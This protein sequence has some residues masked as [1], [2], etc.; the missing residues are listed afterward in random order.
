M[1]LPEGRLDPVLEEAV[2]SQP[3]VAQPQ[4]ASQAREEPPQPA[5]G[6]GVEAAPEAP[7]MDESPRPSKRPAPLGYLAALG[8]GVLVLLGLT[9][10]MK[11]GTDGAPA[12]SAG[13]PAGPGVGG[14][15]STPD[16]Y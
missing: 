7:P 5:P 16:L 2:A 13:A 12:S 14:G 4:E 6:P 10:G 3:K 1:P 9:L 8:A 11:G 15:P